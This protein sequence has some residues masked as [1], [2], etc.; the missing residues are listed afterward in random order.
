MWA[1][2]PLKNIRHA[3]QR[4]APFLTPA[5]RSELML[6]MITDV[7]TA[8]THTPDLAGILLVSRAPEA[9]DLARAHG[10][11]LYAEADGAD[12]SESVQAAGGYLVANRARAAAR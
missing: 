12:L 7:L 3:K 9:T 8:L 10:C 4:L 1:V 5:E 2:V 6:A 11:E